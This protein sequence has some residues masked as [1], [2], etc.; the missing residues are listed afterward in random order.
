MTTILADYV[1]V[2]PTMPK[3]FFSAF[4]MVFCVAV[5]IYIAFRMNRIGGSIVAIACLLVFAFVSGYR[6]TV[7]DPRVL[8]WHLYDLPMVLEFALQE[9]PIWVWKMRACSWA[10]AACA[11]VIG[12]LLYDNPWAR[13]GRAKKRGECLCGYSLVG[14][15]TDT[16]PECGRT[17]SN[18]CTSSPPNA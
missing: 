16:C 2:S 9:N 6:K 13:T 10:G 1:P 11:A 3:Q 8:F 18:P 17:I 12:P 5:P 14:L 15:T 4:I 7:T